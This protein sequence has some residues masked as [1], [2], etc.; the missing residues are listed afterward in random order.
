MAPE[1]CHF[2]AFLGDV[3]HTPAYAWCIR[4]T[5]SSTFAGNTLNSAVY[6]VTV[7][8][9]SRKMAFLIIIVHCVHGDAE[10]F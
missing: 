10:E 5:R 2:S 3:W 8:S 6:A 1:G 4:R 7:G 9:I